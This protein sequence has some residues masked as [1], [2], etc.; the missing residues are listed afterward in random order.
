MSR[1]L[2]FTVCTRKCGTNCWRKLTEE[3]SKKAGIL[4]YYDYDNS[5]F[6]RYGGDKYAAT[7]FDNCRP[8][9]RDEV[10]FYEDRKDE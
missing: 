3:E 8:V 9:R 2:D 10:T 1:S 7:W 5:Q 6:R 4:A